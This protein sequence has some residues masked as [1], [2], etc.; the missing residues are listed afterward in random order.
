MKK[1]RYFLII[2]VLFSLNIFAQKTEEKPIGV[3]PDSFKKPYGSFAKSNLKQ[4]IEA[5]LAAFDKVSPSDYDLEEQK[6]L[7]SDFEK[8]KREM[9]ILE[10][11]GEKTM[12]VTTNLPAGK[13]IYHKWVKR[14]VKRPV[15]RKKKKKC[16]CN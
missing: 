7:K 15:K 14:V 10:G 6:K 16:N 8:Q 11:K 1:A 2:L 4:E 9:A 3:V 12:P 13:K 5:K